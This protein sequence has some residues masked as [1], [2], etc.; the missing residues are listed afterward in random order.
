MSSDDYEAY[1][2]LTEFNWSCLLCLFD[3]L[4]PDNVCDVD[5]DSGLTVSHFD[6]SLLLPENLFSG[7]FTA[8]LHVVHHNVVKVY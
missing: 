6:G 7:P 1:C 8:S 3:V 2:T 5:A 4:P